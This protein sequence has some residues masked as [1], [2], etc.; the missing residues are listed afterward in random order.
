MA[1]RLLHSCG[2]TPTFSRQAP[3]RDVL[4]DGSVRREDFPPHPE[5][6]RWFKVVPSDY[7]GGE[8]AYWRDY[9]AASEWR[10][11]EEFCLEMGLTDAEYVERERYYALKKEINALAVELAQ[12]T[13]QETRHVNSWLVHEHG[14]PWR[15][16]CS[17]DDLERMR[18]FLN[19]WLRRDESV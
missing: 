4:Q 18:E 3:V 7:P 17:T 8:A 13:G 9:D 5:K 14:F 11:R 1:Q 6:G 16:E 12:Q 19:E 15:N 10:T 2:L